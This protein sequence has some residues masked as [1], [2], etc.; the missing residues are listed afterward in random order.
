MSCL[1]CFKKK[2]ESPQEEL[3]VA[4]PKEIAT[5]P[6]QPAEPFHKDDNNP[7]ENG[8][9]NAKTFTFRELAGA[10]K[11][12]KQ[13]CLIGEGGFGRVFKGTLQGGQV[14]AVKQLDRSGTQ[15]NQEFLVELSKLTL[16]KHPNL[17][18]LIGYCADG[19]QRILVFEYLPMG[20][21]EDH[22]HDLKDGKKPLDWL[23][24]MKIALGAA[25]G[26][27]YLHEKANPPI[28]YRDLKPSNILLDQ[29]FNPK[30]SDYGIAKLAGG[31][32]KT[33]MSPM[34]V[35]NGYCAPEFE[36]S[37]ELSM[38]SDVY[39]F[40]V[41][42]LELITGRR[43]VD[44]SRPADE[45]NLVAWAQPFFRDPK[46]FPELA[47]PRLGKKFP[48][49][50]L[51]QAVGVAA[52]CLQDEPM[53]RPLIGDVVA[54]LSFLTMPQPDDPIPSSPPAPT[55]T[56]NMD[57]SNED[58]ESSENEDQGDSDDE[59]QGD[60]DNEDQG[61]S[62]NEDASGESDQKRDEK[63]HDKQHSQ[64]VHDKQRSRKAHDNQE[65]DRG[66]SDYGYGSASGSSEYEDDNGDEQ[67]EVTTKSG[68]WGSAR[69]RH[70][71]KVKS[72]SRSVNSSK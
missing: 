70:K 25:N 39:C 54:A 55:P 13:E 61:N 72:R 38:K 33:N 32:S 48:V 56:S 60:S 53:V 36:R 8:N 37:G 15:G 68:K 52:M 29:D 12:F 10:T 71:S 4:Q 16:L 20:C 11:N 44:T 34:M 62:D 66:S 18:N 24:R 59:D 22:L 19:D 47:D 30:L 45:Q 5:T 21:V 2:S 63:V 17:V 50:S 65:D 58:Q 9:T 49:K 67:G 26:L 64:K 57:K 6:P 42:L 27:E 31:G 46:R 23:S 43:V 28:I 51:N 40:G 1:P 3:P 7:I 35:G 14:V 69:S 41:V